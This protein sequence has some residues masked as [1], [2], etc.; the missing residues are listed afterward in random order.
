MERRQMTD[1][2]AHCARIFED[3]DA[4]ARAGDVEAMLALYH[5]DALFET[6]LVPVTCPDRPDGILRGKAEMRAFF[7]KSS[8]ERPNAILRWH[9]N[10]RWLSDG[11]GK[12]AW[13][14]PRETPD[15]D[16]IDVAEFFDID[17]DGLITAHRVYWGWKGSFAIAPALAAKLANDGGAAR[18]DKS[19]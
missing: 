10:G 6:A 1:F 5:D 19:G 17:A 11:V 18:W 12:L 14:Y 13:E 3:W 15:G 16:Q 2:D 8:A 9:R 7:A 4:A